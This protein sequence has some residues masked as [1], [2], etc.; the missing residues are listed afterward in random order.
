[1]RKKQRV[2]HVYLT[3]IYMDLTKVYTNHVVA[4]VGTICALFLTIHFGEVGNDA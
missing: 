3:S 1:M 2:T 4:Y